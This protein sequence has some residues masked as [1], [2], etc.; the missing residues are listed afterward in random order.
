MSKSTR[1][2]SD[3]LPAGIEVH[4]TVKADSHFPPADDEVQATRSNHLQQELIQGSKTQGV[5]YHPKGRSYS[6]G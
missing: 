4:I 2:N 1:F 6:K 3:A 5:G